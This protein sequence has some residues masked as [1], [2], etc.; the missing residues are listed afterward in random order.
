MPATSSWFEA[1]GFS[2]VR[3]VFWIS[4]DLEV[5]DVAQRRLLDDVGDIV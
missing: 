3:Q 5:Q 2:T 1:E 4:Q